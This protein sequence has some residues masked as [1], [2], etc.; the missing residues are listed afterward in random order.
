MCLLVTSSPTFVGT[1]KVGR[2]ALGAA[3]L[4]TVTL[5]GSADTDIG[6]CT[7]SRPPFMIA[8]GMV[9]MPRAAS[10]AIGPAMLGTTGPHDGIGVAFAVALPP[11]IVTSTVAHPSLIIGAGITDESC[12][13]G[14]RGSRT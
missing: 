3:E 9:T 7:L 5:S 1:T 12:A 6:D 2:V 13:D 4:A 8:T 10:Y 11:A 14:E